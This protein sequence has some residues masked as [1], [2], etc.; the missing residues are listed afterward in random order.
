MCQSNTSKY[1][2]VSVSEPHRKGGRL[3]SQIGSGE[4]SRL[5]TSDFLFSC[6]QPLPV[7]P[8]AAVRVV[9]APR[10]TGSI[11]G[12]VTR[13]ECMCVCVCCRG[14]IC[15]FTKQHRQTV[16]RRSRVFHFTHLLSI[17]INRISCCCRSW[18]GK[19]LV[20]V[21]MYQQWAERVGFLSCFL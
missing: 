1:K 15:L 2:C 17:F 6:L 13:V 21:G 10:V 20:N 4:A 7:L 16:L 11:T 9:S 12:N 5:F 18:W 14:G 19:W 3:W 8:L